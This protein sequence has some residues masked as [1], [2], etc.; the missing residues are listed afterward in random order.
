MKRSTGERVYQERLAA[1]LDGVPFGERDSARA[2][3]AAAASEPPAAVRPRPTG[4]VVV[5]E[6]D[7]LVAEALETLLSGWGW[8]A[9]VASGAEQAWERLRAN[10][11]APALVI[12][13]YRLAGGWTG[14]EAVAW[15]RERLQTPVPAVLFS[16][17]TSGELTERVRAS[18]LRLIPKPIAPETLRAILSEHCQT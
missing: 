1:W 8:P 2:S 6:D 18:G 13:D 10:G 17:D 3:L 5:I 14:I 12:A 4:P 11:A 16:G 15:L 7:T 9:I